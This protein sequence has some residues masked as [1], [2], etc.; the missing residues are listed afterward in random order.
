M[1]SGAPFSLLEIVQ[2]YPLQHKGLGHLAALY[3]LYL[4]FARY[5]LSY[6]KTIYYLQFQCLQRKPYWKPLIISF[7]SSLGSTLLLIE[8]TTIDPLHLWV[9]R[10]PPESALCR[11]E[12]HEQRIGPL[13]QLWVSSLDG[14]DRVNYAPFS[15]L[16][17]P[18]EGI[19]PDLWPAVS[20]EKMSLPLSCLY[21][22]RMRE[23]REQP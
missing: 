11:R 19:R 22:E 18:V 13:R 8:S 23:W 6:H 17:T 9:I 2:A 15:P 21:L 7:Y 20:R 4:L 16:H 14:D 12:R 10:G 1:S 3:L 5:Y